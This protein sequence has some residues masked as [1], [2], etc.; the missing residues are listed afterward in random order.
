MRSGEEEVSPNASTAWTV[1]VLGGTGAQGRGLAVRF[2]ARG[3][4]VVLGSRDGLRGESAAAS[5]RELLTDTTD[6]PVSGGSNADA[7]AAADV[8]VVAT[9]WDDAPDSHAW[10]AEH[11]RDKVVVSCVNPLGFDT[12]GP[13]GL[14]VEAGSAAEHL[15]RQLPDARVAGAF[16]HVAAVRLADLGQD[17]RDEDVLVASDDPTALRVTCELARAVAGRA[18]IDAGRLRM[19]RQLEPWTAVLIAVNRNYRTHSGIALRNVDPTRSRRTPDVL[20]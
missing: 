5:V 12:S 16:H 19:C 1:G 3:H 4:R 2:A 9:P 8:I 7:A 18:G 11:S 15:A 20:G 17:L 6:T 14:Q 13:Y 10:L